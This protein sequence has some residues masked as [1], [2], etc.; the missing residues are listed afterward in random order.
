MAKRDD[1]R[2][3]EQAIQAELLE[4]V[5]VLTEQRKRLAGLLKRANRLPGYQ[6]V[7][8]AWDRGDECATSVA[9][10]LRG[11]LEQARSSTGD[12]IATLRA[13]AE[14]TPERCAQLEDGAREQRRRIKAKVAQEKRGELAVARKLERI[15]KAARRLA[16]EL[17]AAELRPGERRRSSDRRA[18]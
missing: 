5:G 10:E 9:W 14:L 1:G 11:D 17:P 16:A 15:A 4:V 3:Q 13:S 18:A 7:K 6:R 2:A 12:V 8:A